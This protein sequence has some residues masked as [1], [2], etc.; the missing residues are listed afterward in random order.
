MI[1]GD[2]SN[3]TQVYY[4][5]TDIS[6]NKTS[7]PT[8]RNYQQAT[9]VGNKIYAISGKGIFTVEK[10]KFELSK[11]AVPNVMRAIQ[12]LEKL[13]LI[14]IHDPTRPTVESIEKV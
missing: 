3:Q 2:A 9:V 7:I 10:E 11:G 6:Q 1:G 12:S 14:G 5:E 13:V 4:S 8:S